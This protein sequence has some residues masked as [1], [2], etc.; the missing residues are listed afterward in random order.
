MKQLINYETRKSVYDKVSK[1][2][3][4]PEHKKGWPKGKWFMLAL[5]FNPEKPEHVK[6][7]ARQI[8]FD[9]AWAVFQGATKYGE[10]YKLVVCIAGPNGKTID[11][12]RTGWQ[13][14]NGSNF[15]RLINVLPPKLKR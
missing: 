8:R 11:G 6:M 5:G 2:I 15:I 14:D 1:Y 12:I 3:L 9:R 4:N 7:L 13:K 10:V